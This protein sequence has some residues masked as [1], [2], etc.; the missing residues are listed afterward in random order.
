MI[1]PIFQNAYLLLMLKIL[2]H[3]LSVK[4]SDAL[5]VLTV[6][7]CSGLLFPHIGVL[8][9]PIMVACLC[10]HAYKMSKYNFKK[11]LFLATL[12]MLI[13][14][15]FDNI[16]SM[17][18]HAIFAE[19]TFINE[20]LG[21][22]HSAV[23][24]G[25]AILFT[26]LFTKITTNIRT[27]I[28]PNEQFQL[29][30]ASTTTLILTVF[31]GNIILA[32]QRGNGV[33]LIMLNLILLVI[34]LLTGIVIAYRYSK[35][36]REKYASQ[37]EAAEQ[38]SLRKYTAE[39]EM[40]Y[41][42]VRKF[43]HDYQNILSSLEGYFKDKNYEGATRYYF[44][45]IVPAAKVL[46]QHQFE[47]EPLSKIEITEIKSIL[48][49]KLMKAQVLDI[50]ITFE[51]KEVI[52]HIA[53]SSIILVRALGIVLDNAIEEL[54]SLGYGV[55]NVAVI[56]LETAVMFVIQ[57]TCRDNIQRVHIL[58][59]GGFSTKGHNR[60]VGLSTLVDFANEYEN[61]HIETSITNEQ[62]LF[63]QKITIGG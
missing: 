33:K 37:K 31:Y 29:I 56:K 43:K 54:D 27:K 25:L 38:E 14:M 26:I 22:I 16:T 12:T 20:S 11:S 2:T 13:A 5:F 50:A 51:A 9:S 7:I 49:T 34:Y 52:D 21:L 40:Q 30:L 39:I 4:V 53:L 48:S 35:M 46:N 63:I 24:S 59:Q 41:T 55:L 3:R 44:D 36:L 32:Q 61:L 17:I 42:K 23:S 6:G 8:I 1:I 58:K 47:L 18:L 10:Y 28:N 19:T 45:K 57:N 15:L 62:K 60:G